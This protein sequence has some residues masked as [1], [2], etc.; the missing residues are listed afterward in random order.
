M[1]AYFSIS[2]DFHY[3]ILRIT[4]KKTCL[5]QSCTLNGKTAYL[6]IVIRPS[7]FAYRSGMFPP[8]ASVTY[9]TRASL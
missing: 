4:N 2:Y 7:G 1:P 5:M 6:M 8:R 3:I 9:F